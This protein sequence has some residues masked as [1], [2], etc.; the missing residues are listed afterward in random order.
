MSFSGSVEVEG[1]CP[2]DFKGI[3]RIGFKGI[4]RSS[5]VE[6]KRREK[7]FDLR[8]EPKEENPLEQNEKPQVEVPYAFAQT[9][10][11][12]DGGLGAPRSLFC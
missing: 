1:R 8:Q 11:A 2:I 5:D 7:P 3:F 6:F 10:L 4:F 12:I 9:R